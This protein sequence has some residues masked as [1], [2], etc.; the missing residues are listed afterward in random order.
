MLSLFVPARHS[1]E[2]VSGHFDIAACTGGRRWRLPVEQGVV[3]H[4]STLFLCHA[5]GMHS[6]APVACTGFVQHVNTV[7]WSMQVLLDHTY[8]PG[9]AQMITGVLCSSNCAV[10]AVCQ[11]FWLLPHAQGSCKTH[12]ARYT[13]LPLV[14]PDTRENAGK[15]PLIC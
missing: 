11:L 13:P 8:T 6:E 9:E 3:Y 10:A 14:R 1:P 2:F 12:T 5:F 7:R 4:A 15:Q